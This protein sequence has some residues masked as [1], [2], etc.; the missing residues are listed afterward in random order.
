M[1]VR[2]ITVRPPQDLFDR[3]QAK[4]IENRRPINVQLAF[5]LETI[6]GLSE[7]ISSKLARASLTLP[8]ATEP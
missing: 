1:K 7:E 4:A 6:Y 8:T 5:D 3:L 2:Q